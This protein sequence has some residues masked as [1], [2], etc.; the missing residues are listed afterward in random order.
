MAVNTKK[1]KKSIADAATNL[2]TF[3]YT[4]QSGA[5]LLKTSNHEQLSAEHQ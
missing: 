4:T 2:S 5:W 3:D 1:S